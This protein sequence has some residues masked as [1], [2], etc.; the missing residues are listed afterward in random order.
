ME[1]LDNPEEGVSDIIQYGEYQWIR[2]QESFM[3]SWGKW[4]NLKSLD[5]VDDGSGPVCVPREHNG[6]C[7]EIDT[8]SKWIVTCKENR[9][10]STTLHTFI[11]IESCMMYGSSY[12][13][14][15]EQC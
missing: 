15:I 10:T 8:N 11:Q 6:S 13:V 2:F 5:C 9:R 12:T 4:Q 3:S 14:Q 1:I 7:V